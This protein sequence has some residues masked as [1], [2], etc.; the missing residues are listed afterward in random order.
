MNS[1]EIIKNSLSNEINAIF[2]GVILFLALLDIVI[3]K[4]LKSQIVS[5]GVLGTFV[6]IFIGLQDFNPADMKNSINSILTGLKTA[7][8]TSIVGMTTASFL[9]IFQKVFNK[10]IDDE[11]NEERLLVE[12]SGIHPNT[13]K[14]VYTSNKEK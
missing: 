9:A 6:G 11:K 8:F 13:P 14:V 4:D 2:V 7:F 10:Q 1:I 3:K 12:I 5:I